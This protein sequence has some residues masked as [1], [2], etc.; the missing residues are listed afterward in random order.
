MEEEAGRRGHDEG[1][2]SGKVFNNMTQGLLMNLRTL[3]GST[4]KFI[5]V[6]YSGIGSG[7]PASNVK[8]VMTESTHP[9]DSLI[10][11]YPKRYSISTVLVTGMVTVNCTND[12]VAPGSSLKFLIDSDFLV[13]LTG[14]SNVLV[15]L[16]DPGCFSV[17]TGTV[18]STLVLEV[19]RKSLCERI[20]LDG[21]RGITD[22]STGQDVTV[23]EVVHR[24]PV[25]LHV[26]FNDQT[27]VG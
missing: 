10:D 23:R 20:F 24:L 14:F 17:C 12:V 16:E 8:T 26:A 25:P 9:R 7:V 5:Q 22:G 27:E 21:P 2:G 15:S 18:T 19:F 13:S 11:F 6:Q 1:E 3:Q 4:V